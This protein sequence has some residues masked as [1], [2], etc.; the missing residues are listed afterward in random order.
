MNETLAR[1]PANISASERLRREW[2]TLAAMVHSYCKG[3][4]GA[5][6]GLCPECRD[7]LEYATR[8]LDA[9]R[10]GSDKPTCANC[11]VHCY[12]PRYRDQVKRIMRRTGPWMAWRHPLWSVWHCL[13]GFRK[14][15]VQKHH[16]NQRIG[17][18]G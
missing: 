11:P 18:A 10:F 16:E 2:R 7:L 12:A 6:S 8:R 17:S 9:C 15:P 1:L 13:D 3:H 14:P 4:H 5:D